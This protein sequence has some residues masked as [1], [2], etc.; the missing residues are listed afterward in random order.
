MKRRLFRSWSRI[1]KFSQSNF[2]ANIVLEPAYRVEI[3]EDAAGDQKILGKR[4]L[5]LEMT[6]QEVVFRYGQR[7]L[8]YHEGRPGDRKS[9]VCGNLLATPRLLYTDGKPEKRL[10]FVAQKRLDVVRGALS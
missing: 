7:S 4:K 6:P 5:K 9:A 2:D 10:R 3:V 8:W 1:E